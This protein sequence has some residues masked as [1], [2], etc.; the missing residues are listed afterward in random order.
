MTRAEL[1]D[2]AGLIKEQ[3]EGGQ[4]EG[5]ISKKKSKFETKGKLRDESGLKSGEGISDGGL[6]VKDPVSRR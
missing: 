3:A 1:S 6:H 5:R 2:G 4:V